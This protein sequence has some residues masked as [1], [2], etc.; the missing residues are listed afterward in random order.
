MASIRKEIRIDTPP[1]DVWNALRDVGAP[2]WNVAHG[3]H[4]R[5][6]RVDERHGPAGH[7]RIRDGVGEGLVSLIALGLFETT[8]GSPAWR[9]AAAAALIGRVAK[10]AAG[11]PATTGKS[12]G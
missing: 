7:I 10:Y 9:S 1:Q 11:P 8:A 5:A 6:R 3:R 12:I 4:R 2:Q